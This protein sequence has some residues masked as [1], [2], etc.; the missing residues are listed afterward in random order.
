MRLCPKCRTHH[1]DAVDL[2]RCGYR[3]SS[4]RGEQPKSAPTRSSTLAK[5]FTWVAILVF[6]GIAG[7]MAR[8]SARS[9]AE[10][11]FSSNNASVTADMLTQMATELSSGLPIMIDNETRLD[12]MSAGPD[13]KITYHYTLVR[14]ESSD[15]T[16]QQLRS[17]REHGVIAYVCTNEDMKAFRENGVVVSYS[18]RGNDGGVIGDILV[19][20]RDCK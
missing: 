6:A 8:R 14:L 11:V 9:G 10:A 12:K 13:K 1:S 7:S 20:P 19:Y 17:A 16:A 3:F 5:V 4:S 15:I 18:Y 2:C